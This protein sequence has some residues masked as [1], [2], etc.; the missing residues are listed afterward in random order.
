MEKLNKR[1]TIPKKYYSQ[2]H[3]YDLFTFDEELTINE[4]YYPDFEFRDAPKIK[5][6][7]DT[8]INYLKI[9][10]LIKNINANIFIKRN[11]LYNPNFNLN[12]FYNNLSDLKVRTF[13]RPS[14]IPMIKEKTDASYTPSQNEITIYNPFAL[15]ALSHELYH[16][17]TS[18]VE[19]DFEYIG[20]VQFDLEKDVE[21]GNG[22]N[23]GYTDLIDTMTFSS[24]EYYAYPIPV[25]VMKSIMTLVGK[26]KLDDF[27]SNMNLL[28]LLNELDLLG[29][30]ERFLR[31]AY[32]I[33]LMLEIE[34]Q[35][36]IDYVRENKKSFK[37]FQEEKIHYKVLN[38]LIF[39][40]I[41]IA[42]KKK[43][44]S[45]EDKES[46]KIMLINELEKLYSIYD[47]R[48]EYENFCAFAGR[49]IKDKIN[50]RAVKRLTLIQN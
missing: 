16:A 12:N 48:F 40:K 18:V 28:G 43:I 32:N 7:T 26:D 23:E 25:E 30:K 22:I 31:L 21:F 44:N 42:S 15:N 45:K 3:Y 6:P 47:Q 13:F 39:L 34:D 5:T 41:F 33:D 29:L 38:D 10:E 19:D 27:Y 24:T 8:K 35:Y 11:I 37:R 17:A 36:S 4:R 9:S 1:Y 49:Q 20:F 46:T 50:D 14:Y 2:S